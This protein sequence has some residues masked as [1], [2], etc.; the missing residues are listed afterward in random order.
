MKNATKNWDMD[1]SKKEVKM[2]DLEK[3]SNS[4]RK[5]ERLLNNGS[6]HSQNVQKS[7]R[8]SHAIDFRSKRYPFGYGCGRNQYAHQSSG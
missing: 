4:G 6:S 2:K 3:S 7:M 8:L 1:K 5:V